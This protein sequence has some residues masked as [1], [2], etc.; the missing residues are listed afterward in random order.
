[1]GKLGGVAGGGLA[2]TAILA[3][4]GW[5]GAV[6]IVGLAIAILTMAA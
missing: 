3:T 4:L 2:V 1:M 6:I 5:P